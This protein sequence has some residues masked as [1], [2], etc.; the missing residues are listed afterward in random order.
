MTMDSVK[1]ST[2]GGSI[3]APA[4][5]A[6]S[7]EIL[8]VDDDAALCGSL[9]MAFTLEGYQVTTFRDGRS[10]VDAARTRKPA[11]VLLDVCT[12]GKSGL[13]I[14]KEVDAGTYGAPIF[15]MS[16]HGDIPT[17]VEAI[18]RGACDFIEKRLA[19]DAFIARVRETIG[20]WARRRRENGDGEVLPA[21]FPG[22]DRLTPREREVLGRIIAAATNGETAEMLGISRRTVEIHR[23]H[24][25]HKL[26]ARNSVDL[27]RIV[28]GKGPGPHG[29][30]PRPA[31]HG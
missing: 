21:S 25:M 4:T 12:P 15:I 30:R 18:R 1:Q 8:I 16:A 13:D 6:P 9:A 11:C 2:A 31:E 22:S 24:I 27:V 5:D 23:V 17:A 10:F 7:N 3:A 26:G 20:V 29:L 28:L 19:V 14:L